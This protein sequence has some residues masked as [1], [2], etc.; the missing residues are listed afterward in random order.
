MLGMTFSTRMVYRSGEEQDIIIRDTDRDLGYG[1]FCFFLINDILNRLTGL[2]LQSV[3]VFLTM[4]TSGLQYVVQRMNYKR[5][6][7][8]IE[9]IT[10]E[11][12]LAAWGPKMTPNKGQ[13]KVRSIY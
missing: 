4:V 9:H 13:R 1:C 6:L 11:A 10:K 12:K 3:L 5:D 8:R 2:F 7:D